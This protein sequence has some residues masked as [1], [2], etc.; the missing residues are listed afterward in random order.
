MLKTLSKLAV[1]TFVLALNNS[2]YR[3]HLFAFYHSYLI[4]IGNQVFSYLKHL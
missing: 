4:D 3:V 2:T 1:D